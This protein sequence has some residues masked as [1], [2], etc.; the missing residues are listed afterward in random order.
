MI[1][2]GDVAVAAGQLVELSEPLAVAW[3]CTLCW[4]WHRASCTHP[5]ALPR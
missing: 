4:T 5:L 2:H 1:R 3:W